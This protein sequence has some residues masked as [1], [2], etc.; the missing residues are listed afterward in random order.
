LPD[1]FEKEAANILPNPITI[2]ELTDASGVRKA[3]EIKTE[4][5]DGSPDSNVGLLFGKYEKTLEDSIITQYDIIATSAKEG[6]TVT[7]TG[8]EIPVQTS[9]DTAV[10]ASQ[11]NFTGSYTSGGLPMGSIALTFDTKNTAAATTVQDDWNLGI[12]LSASGMAINAS[13]VGKEKTIA[14]GADAKAEGTVDLYVFGMT[15]PA[16]S[17][18]Y[19]TVSGE[20]AA[21]PEI[22]ADSVRLGKMSLEELSAWI[23][24]M[25]P[26][27]QGQ[28]MV[29]MGNLP[30][31]IIKM[32]MGG[33][34]AQ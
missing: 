6:L 20:P 29:A 13:L 5:P 18:A 22:P 30:P 9:G 28:L 31:S 12:D 34:T 25:R 19:N 17:I 14:D 10:T 32:I 23:E 27:L 21:L 4:I 8:K 3:L 1:E 26:V 2:T 15:E 16:L 33:A 7:F 11:W 24:E